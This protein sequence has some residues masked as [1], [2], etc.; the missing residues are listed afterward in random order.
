[1]DGQAFSNPER[2][3]VFYIE[4]KDNDDVLVRKAIFVIQR[5]APEL[6]HDFRFRLW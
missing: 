3:G 2:V 1:M 6:L 4:T 5:V